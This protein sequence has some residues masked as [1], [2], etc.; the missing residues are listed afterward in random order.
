MKTQEKTAINKPGRGASEGTGPAGTLVS[1]VQPPGLGDDKCLL[2]KL[3]S[4]WYFVTQLLQQTNREQVTQCDE[5]G[6]VCLGVQRA[7]GAS[8][9]RFIQGPLSTPPPGWAAVP[10]SKGSPH[11]HILRQQRCSQGQC[12]LLICTKAPFRPAAP[13]SKGSSMYERLKHPTDMCEMSQ[14]RNR[15][16]IWKKSHKVSGNMFNKKRS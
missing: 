12:F 6:P 16:L 11:C 13:L 10:Q 4:V 3:P 1:H 5:S 15:V 14:K 9:G 2:L 7:P 8:G